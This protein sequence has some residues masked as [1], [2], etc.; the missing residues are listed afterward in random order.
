MSSTQ[1]REID[2]L[3]RRVRELEAEL[4]DSQVNYY[5]LLKI[6][7]RNLKILFNNSNDLV[8]TFRKSGEVLFCNNSLNKKLGFSENEILALNLSDI[9]N[10]DH[11]NSVLDT[12]KR[13]NTGSEFEKFETVL[14]SKSEKNIYVN[15]NM[16]SVVERGK[17]AEYRCVFYDI[18]ERI[19]AET[20]QS[21]YYQI[22]NITI[23]E[24]DLQQ[25]YKTIYSKLNELLRVKNFQ[26]SF[27]NRTGHYQ[28]FCINE[29][30]DKGDMIFDVQKALIDYTFLIDNAVVLDQKAIAKI[31]TDLGLDFQDPV[32]KIW[33]GVL[34]ITNSKI[35]VMSISS[36]KDESAF[37]DKDLELL[38]YIAGQI[39]L[40]IERQANERKIESQAATLGAIFDSSTHEIWSVDKKLRFTSFNDNYE[41]AFQRYYNI[42]PKIGESLQEVSLDKLSMDVVKFWIEKYTKAFSGE[43]VNFQIKTKDWEGKLVW[44]EV[45][46]NP[47]FLPNDSIEEIAIIANDITK[48]KESE[49]ALIASEEKFRNIFVSF[50]D[51]YFRCNIDGQ[52]TMVSPS[53]EEVLGFSPNE[54][55]GKKIIDYIPNR[56]EIIN[57]VSRTYKE[58]RI[59]NL[60][61]HIK[62]AKGRVL[63]F[64]FNIRLIQ[65]DDGTIEVE[66]V[67]RDITQLRQANTQL[68]KAKEMAEHSLKVKER[69]LA[70]MSHEIRTP[71]N[72]IIGMVDLLASTELSDEQEDYLK[73][74]KI[75]SQTLLTILNDIL[76][77]SKIEAGKMTL[78]K[79]PLN[80]TKT[81]E[82]IYRFYSQEA[83]IKGHT[84]HYHVDKRIPEWIEGDETRLIQ[85]VSNLLSNALKFNINKGDINMSV[86]LDT[87]DNLE[88]TIK[89]SV[90]D[91]GIGIS[92]ED[93]NKLFQ[94]FNQLDNSQTKNFGGTGL[95][96][97][98]SKEL[99]KVMGGDIG[100]VSS[101]G[102][103]STFWFTFITKEITP[104]T[105]RS[106]PEMVAL[107]NQF[108]EKEP[109]ILLVD[110]N[111][112]NRKV[113]SRILIK[114]GCNVTLAADGFEAIEKAKLKTYDLILMD[115]QM[116]EMDGVET[117]QKIKNMDLAY[118]PPIIAMTAYSMKEDEER[119]IKAGLDG[120]IAKPL[121]ANA[122][123]QKVKES[124][125]PGSLSE[126]TTTTEKKTDDQ[127]LNYD[128]LNQLAKYGGESLIASALKDFEEETTLLIEKAITHYENGSFEKVKGE[129][130]TL[131]GNSGTLGVEKL[132]TQSKFIEKSLKENN[133]E[134]LGDE[135]E[136]LQKLFE[137]FQLAH[138]NTLITNE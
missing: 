135:L 71:M 106:E 53:V 67:A 63:S 33:L 1:H 68:T 48:K 134:E 41:A 10:K 101:K 59:R 61:G 45:F 40:V 64:Y 54:V 15:G 80:L 114:C 120:Y 66:V 2:S 94:N 3:K 23:K 73:T 100:V 49:N 128:T 18:T 22:G 30:N 115:I 104:E 117:T 113:A 46:I 110:D 21:L 47:I 51:I 26:I 75:S 87:Q 42:V 74:I 125:E 105:N 137:E 6:T 12:M 56:R 24:N 93:Q 131:K 79:E 89:V 8:I 119:F 77:L 107:T 34:I 129:L 32:P 5:S 78:K 20:A 14:I 97:V 38:N 81:M 111:E 92:K 11:I 52:I 27:K 76:D 126:A 70:N 123:I 122:L 85:I 112:V 118:L 9:V 82:K 91:S 31:G 136:T 37:N 108:N 28:E 109:C 96:L 35:G 133:F 83:S 7:N 103:G 58:K 29:N 19:R 132:H 57:M 62:D 84:I 99:V 121:K 88:K 36:Y 130:H 116:P 60:E 95:G 43:A 55:V 124:L 69:F 65:K 102:R 127:I 138:K 90:K 86:M 4:K 25:L 39:S 16:T 44:R 98:I 72:G 50:Q 17:P 13:I